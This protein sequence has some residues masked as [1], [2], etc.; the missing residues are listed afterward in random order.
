MNA[1]KSLSWSNHSFNFLGI[2]FLQISIILMV[3]IYGIY[4]YVIWVG[5]G[6]GGVETKST[7]FSSTTGFVVFTFFDLPYFSPASTNRL[8]YVSTNILFAAA[9]SMMS[10]TIANSSASSSN[11]DR[12]S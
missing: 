12:I 4:S 1:W 5:D 6:S 2:A 11:S 7:I 9:S 8:N 10:T 3:D